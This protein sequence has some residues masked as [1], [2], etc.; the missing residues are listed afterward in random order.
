MMIVVGALLFGLT[1]FGLAF[2][3]NIY[4]RDEDS[5][6][7]QWWID[8]QVTWSAPRAVALALIPISAI[9]VLAAYVYLALNVTPRPG[10]E[11]LVLPILILL[12]VVFV[13]IQ[14]LHIRLIQ[15]TLSRTS[16]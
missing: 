8:G 9:A 11:S 4:F 3:A 7:M 13:A 14:V 16:D 15:K 2:R 5:L 6:P 12:G 10:Q 1:L